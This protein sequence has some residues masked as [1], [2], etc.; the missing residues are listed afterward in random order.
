MPQWWR[1]QLF[2][3]DARQIKELF[4][5]FNS[6]R[7]HTGSA[8]LCV[9]KP[10]RLKQ[11]K[12]T[13]LV[14]KWSAVPQAET[15]RF[16]SSSKLR[17][18]APPP[19]LNFLFACRYSAEPS[20]TTIAVV[21]CSSEV[22]VSTVHVGA[23][24]AEPSA[25]SGDDAGTL[26]TTSRRN[27]KKQ[28]ILYCAGLSFS[29]SLLLRQPKCTSA[30]DN[31]SAVTSAGTLQPGLGKKGKHIKKEQDYILPESLREICSPASNPPT[32]PTPHSPPPSP[33]KTQSRPN[34][35]SSE[36][37]YTPLAHIYFGYVS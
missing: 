18:G 34:V 16:N 20:R 13:H 25:S 32:H 28:H 2:L 36:S 12:M 21:T 30:N 33:P 3:W 29:V 8:H 19:E 35:P 10:C 23:G 27:N 4:F 26:L 11:G 7:V 17:A 9:A 1:N 22:S 6:N 14:T 31:A 24:W 37:C 5:V 15:L